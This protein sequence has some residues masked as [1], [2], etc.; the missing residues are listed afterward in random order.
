MENIQ[1][2]L[3]SSAKMVILLV[4]TAMWLGWVKVLLY[5]SRKKN[6]RNPLTR[7]LLRG[8]GQSLSK[9]LEDVNIDLALY[10][11]MSMPFLLVFVLAYWGFL[12]TGALAIATLIVV[13]VMGVI[14]FT[15]LVYRALKRRERLR[16]GYEAEVAVGEELNHLMRWGFWV[17]HDLPMD[18]FNIDHV[19]I[20]KTGVFAVET[21]GRSKPD[22]GKGKA[23]AR[24]VYDGRK[25]KFPD[26]FE[27]QPIEQARRQAESLAKWLASAV[28]ERVPVRPALAIPG[29]YID[30]QSGEMLIYNGKNPESTFEKQPVVLDDKMIQRIAHQV[31]QKCRDVTPRAVRAP[32]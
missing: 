13:V 12:Y 20:G 14:V 17:Y 25:L 7:D 4:L 24:L 15:I 23:D 27:T 29:W 32:G 30:R 21:K 11:G 19:V 9:S 18:G 10:L 8:P 2:V 28:G 5:L 31:E 1:L 26:K 22:T 6:R 16:L 3:T